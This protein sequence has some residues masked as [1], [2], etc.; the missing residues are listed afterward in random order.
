MRMLALAVLLVLL[1]GPASASA[2]TFVARVIGVTDG[3]TLTVLRAGHPEVIR[4]RGI[5]APE[6]GQPYGERAKQ[7][8]AALAFSQLVAVEAA[9]RDR[10]GRLLGEVR[11]SDGRS[12][13][14]ELVRAGSAW[15]FCRYSA[16]PLLARLEADARLARRGLWA[17]PRPTPP[18]DYR[19]VGRRAG[20]A[21]HGVRRS[22]TSPRAC[23]GRCKIAA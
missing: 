17:D 22:C 8:A 7:H 2:E 1:A 5:D 19:S 16:D 21:I 6:R 18:W 13:N 9:E 10:Y 3:D 14:Q 12:L 23:A 11:L 15:W 4:L 20:R